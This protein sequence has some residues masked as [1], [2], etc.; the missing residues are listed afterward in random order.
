MIIAITAAGTLELREPDDFK[1]FKIAVEK[2]GMTDAEITAALKSIA[3]P[4]G[5]G[6]HYW[7][8]QAAMKNWNSNPQ[9]ADW[10]ASFDA[11]LE[12]V[13]KYGYVDEATGNVK[14]H[15]EHA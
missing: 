11:M 1:G 5:D 12:K 4:D 10:S 2:P 6:K 8:T 7:V 3:T 15:I 9:P 13:K 14:A